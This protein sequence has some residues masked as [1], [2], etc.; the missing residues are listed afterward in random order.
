[1]G[2]IVDR[3][4]K[5]CPEA[6]V[7]FDITEDN[8]CVGLSFLASG[9]Y[10]LI[11][12]GPYFHNLDH[13]HDD[14]CWSNVFVHPGPARPDLCR[15]ALAYDTWIPSTLF[16]THYLP[17]DPADSQ[18]INI[19]SLILGHSGIWGDLADISKEGRQRFGKWLGF[20]KRV[21]DDITQAS[22]VRSGPV[23]GSP[24]VH[25]KIHAPTGHG[26]IVL[27]AS[28]P[29]EYR[30]ISQHR[31]AALLAATPNLDVETLDDGRASLTFRSDGPAAAIAFFD[32]D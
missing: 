5:A 1:M 2:R 3:L 31:P 20:Y 8:R 21:R 14:S 12:N 32:K 9:K 24:E 26:A 30:Y 17:D 28:A 7:D 19:A 13:P 23:G 18:M 10:F 25:E 22:P 4:C 29:G 11:N 27:F 16:L 6:I 15:T